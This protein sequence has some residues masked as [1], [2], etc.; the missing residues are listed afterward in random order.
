MTESSEDENPKV[1]VE[2]QPSE[3]KV[4]GFEMIDREVRKSGNTGRVYL[5][6]NWIGSRIKIIR[7]SEKRNEQQ[8]HSH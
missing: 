8:K 1:K 4:V 2:N 3:F 7:V 5:P 6:R